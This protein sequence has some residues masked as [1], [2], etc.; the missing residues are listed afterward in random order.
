MTEVLTEQFN[1]Y[2]MFKTN[3]TPVIDF[4][5]TFR[6]KNVNKFECLNTKL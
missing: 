2:S 5:I 1:Y 6:N 4:N 3:K